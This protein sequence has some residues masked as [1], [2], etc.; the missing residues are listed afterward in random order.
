[1]REEFI[2]TCNQ[3]CKVTTV[4]KYNTLKGKLE[5]MAARVPQLTLGLNGGM[6]KGHTYLVPTEE[7]AYQDVTCQNKEM[8]NG[9]LQTL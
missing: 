4:S 1:M 3:L 2:D 9:S 7:V 6:T 8:L 5:E